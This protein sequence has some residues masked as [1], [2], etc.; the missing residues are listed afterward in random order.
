MTEHP[1]QFAKVDFL[2]SELLLKTPLSFNSSSRR[3]TVSMLGRTAESCT[4]QSEISSC[5]SAGMRLGSGDLY[6]FATCKPAEA[7]CKV[8]DIKRLTKSGCRV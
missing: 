2:G 7:I 1:V 8:V 3:S 4:Q 5:S 6:P